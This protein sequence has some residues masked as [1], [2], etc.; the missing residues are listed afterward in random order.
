MLSLHV[1]DVL[2]RATLLTGPPGMSV[3]D[4]ASLMQANG[5]GAVLVVDAARLVGILTE[6]DIV[7]RVVARDLDSHATTV[8]RVMTPS[9]MTIRPDRTLGHALILMHKN[10]FR[11]LPVLEGDRVLGL[12]SARNALDPELEEF[13]V[14]TVRREHYVREGA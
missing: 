9:P 10:G 3:F 2:D 8:A 14:E 4:A 7:F 1:R 5:R 12:V 6:R 13:V 11:R